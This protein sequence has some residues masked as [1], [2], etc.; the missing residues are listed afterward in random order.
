M[1]VEAVVTPPETGGTEEEV[2]KAG[3]LAL[4]A[5]LE[6]DPAVQVA[7]DAE[8]EVWR[9][10]M[11]RMIGFREDV[12][13]NIGLRAG[14]SPGRGAWVVFTGVVAPA[15]MDGAAMAPPGGNG[16]KPVGGGIPNDKQGG[17]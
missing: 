3:L 12:R 1:E 14:I 11:A 7:I 5:A 16:S 13:V 2:L 9:K 4:I 6:A 10:Q 17:A 8:L 15:G